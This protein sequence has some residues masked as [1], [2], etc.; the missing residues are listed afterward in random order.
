MI[1]V[2]GTMTI[3]PS[4]LALFEQLLPAHMERTLAQD[5]C[6]MFAL[7]VS[8]RATG[9]I[10]VA[11]AWKDEKSLIRHHQQSFTKEFVA[12]FGGILGHDCRVY[13]V[14]QVRA[15]PSLESGANPA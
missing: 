6:L 3:K 11:E 4:E 15:V 13:E 8:N 7:G 9:L 10:A 12:A 5:F 14:S 1:V 2:A